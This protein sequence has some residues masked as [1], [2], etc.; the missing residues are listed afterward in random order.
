MMTPE[1]KAKKVAELG[2]WLASNPKH[3]N[4]ATVAK[5]KRDLEYELAEHE[6][7]HNERKR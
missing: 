2:E 7:L 4:H 5:D 6:K 1:Q 3:P